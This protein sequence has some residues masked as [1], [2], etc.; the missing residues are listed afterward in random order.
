M[1]YEE[2]KKGYGDRLA[3]A[4]EYTEQYILLGDDGMVYIEG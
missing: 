2:F 4:C 3:E 1:S